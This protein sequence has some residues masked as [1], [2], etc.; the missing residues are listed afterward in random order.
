MDTLIFITL[1]GMLVILFIL[2]LVIKDLEKRLEELEEKN[3][4]NK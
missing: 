2:S 1:I 3:R 4:D